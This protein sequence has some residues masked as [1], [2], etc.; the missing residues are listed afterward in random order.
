MAQ[1]PDGAVLPSWFQPQ[2]PQGLRNDKTL[3]G[4]IRGR[5][6]LKDLEAFESGLTTRGL[7]G[8]HT[9]NGLVEDA[10]RGAE[11]KGA[12]CRVETVTFPKVGVVLDCIH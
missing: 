9:A 1:P 12:V 6:T 5:D 3:L 7:V 4:I 2:D 11:V 10:G 8:N